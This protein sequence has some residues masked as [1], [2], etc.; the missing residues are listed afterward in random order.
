M[1][2]RETAVVVGASLAGLSAVRALRQQGFDGR[3]VLLGDEPHLP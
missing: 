2:V 1:T 3:V